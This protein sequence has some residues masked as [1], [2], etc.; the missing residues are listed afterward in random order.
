MSICTTAPKPIKVS[1]SR[2]KN[3]EACHQ[4]TKLL[5]DGN[6]S[7]VIDGRAFL[8]GT[9]ADRAMR[10]WLEQGKITQKWEP[11][12]MVTYLDSLWEDHVGEGAEYTI[13]WKGDAKKDKKKVLTQVTDALTR[14]EPILFEKV[15][16]FPY[17]PE[18]RFT[19]TMGIKD[20]SGQTV[21]VE[22]FG[23]VDVAVLYPN[24]NY[25]LFDLK[26]T[27]NKAY[28]ESC[29]GQLVFYSIAFRGWTGVWPKE[30][31]LWSPL[32]NPAVIP[33]VLT[34]EDIRYMQSRIM[35]YCQGIWRED[36][37]LTR[38]ES[39]CYNCITKHACPRW[40][41]PV[42]VDEQGRNRLS[43]SRPP[44]ILEGNTDDDSGIQAG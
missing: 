8:P 16:P 3:F 34:Q 39:N 38:D 40:K 1:W 43:F 24:D 41:N 33:L 10:M 21:H 37:S 15:V 29:L 25:G 31:A 44:L 28:I 19:S 6:K 9:L 17:Q 13:K 5:I 35:A 26:L 30:F 36:W 2:I 12:S 23:A 14:L 4:R 18:Y 27:E 22:I 32:M 11:G 42:Q 20:L 7:K